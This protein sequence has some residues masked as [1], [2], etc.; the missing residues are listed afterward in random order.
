MVKP[1]DKVKDFGKDV[2]HVNEGKLF[3]IIC[4]IVLD[5]IKKDRIVNHIKGPHHVA[6][7]EKKNKEQ[8]AAMWQQQS[9][10]SR[11]VVCLHNKMKI[12]NTEK[13]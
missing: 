10:S 13:R 12:I 2:L 8:R 5:Y 6:A 9:N 7:M 11:L 3:C 1:Q 4:G